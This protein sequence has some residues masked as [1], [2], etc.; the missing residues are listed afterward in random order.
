MHVCA[1]VQPKNWAL[2]FLRKDDS[3]SSSMSLKTLN[4]FHFQRSLSPQL[5][6]LGEQV[7][8]AL[9]FSDKLFE[10]LLVRPPQMEPSVEP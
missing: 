9:S 2:K 8:T 10:C 1:F 4:V 7:T 3:L 6:E 5:D